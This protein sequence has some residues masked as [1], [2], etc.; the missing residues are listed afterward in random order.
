MGTYKYLSVTHPTADEE[1]SIPI[2]LT[3]MQRETNHSNQST[4]P[5]D[6]GLKSAATTRPNPS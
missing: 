4:T 1:R 3:F 6:V 5:E 2:R